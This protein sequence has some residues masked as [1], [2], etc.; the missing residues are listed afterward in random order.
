MHQAG[1][2]QRCAD[3]EQAW[4]SV[5]LLRS[6]G[7]AALMSKLNNSVVSRR[8]RNVVPVNYNILTADLIVLS[9]G[10]RLETLQAGPRPPSNFRQNLYWL[11]ALSLRVGS[12]VRKSSRSC[13]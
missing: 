12:S 13:T 6:L 11:G 10:R 3:A 9:L 8:L 7:T 1:H 5:E 4:H 2:V